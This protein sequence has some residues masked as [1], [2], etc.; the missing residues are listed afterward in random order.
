MSKINE[1]KFE[2][3]DREQVEMTLTKNQLSTSIETKNEPK[4][5]DNFKGMKSVQSAIKILKIEN[6][7]NYNANEYVS[8]TILTASHETNFKKQ[9]LLRNV[10]FIKGI[11]LTKHENYPRIIKEIALKTNTKINVIRA[12]RFNI[13]STSNSIVVA[14][15]ETFEMKKNLIYNSKISKLTANNIC[16][17]WPKKNIYIGDLLSN[18]PL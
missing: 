13:S 10:I 14:K 4:R 11:P 16:S 5:S 7:K 1:R 17:N 3:C 9:L 8:N 15:L 12:F 2:C 6:E 18:R